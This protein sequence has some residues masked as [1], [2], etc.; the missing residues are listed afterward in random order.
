MHFIYCG[1]SYSL[2][3]GGPGTFAP[4]NPLVC[5]HV[6]APGPFSGKLQDLQ[7][8]TTALPLLC[9]GDAE[10]SPK[11]TWLVCVSAA[12][13][14][15]CWA[16]G[17]VSTHYKVDARS[18]TLLPEWMVA[19]SGLVDGQPGTLRSPAKHTVGGQSHRNRET[20]KAAVV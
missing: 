13:T 2:S 6:L 1:V 18:L 3:T 17:H 14:C 19:C 5:S 8:Q 10:I 11:E 20:S 15:S 9:M 7:I 12:L 4:P 16:L